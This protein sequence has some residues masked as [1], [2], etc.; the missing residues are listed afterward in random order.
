VSAQEPLTQLKAL[1]LL[2]VLYRDR[3]F[4]GYLQGKT[5]GATCIM[6]QAPSSNNWGY[7]SFFGDAADYAQ[8]TDTNKYNYTGVHWSSWR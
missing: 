5:P 3:N 7:N 6:A 8:V 2:L 4:L 1:W